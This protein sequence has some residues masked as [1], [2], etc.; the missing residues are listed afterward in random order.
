MP[1]CFAFDTETVEGEPFTI[2]FAGRFGAEL[3]VIKRSTILT[4]FLR[5][6]WTRGSEDSLSIL[7]AHNLEFDLGVVFINHVE[8]LWTTDSATLSFPM[9][10]GRWVRLQLHSS[11]IPHVRLDLG[12]KRWL[13][14]DTMSFFPRLSLEDACDLLQLSVRKLESPPGLGQRYP[15]AAEWAYFREYAINDAVATFELGQFILRCHEEFGINPTVS[16]ADLASTIFRTHFLHRPCT[17]PGDSQ[18]IRDNADA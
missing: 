10:D 2:Q 11:G 6:L 15:T 13:L 18:N 1:P 9:G 17:D 16:V 12:G 4:M 14:L 3:A 8:R 5:F 7:F